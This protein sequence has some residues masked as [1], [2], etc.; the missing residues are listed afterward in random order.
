MVIGAIY[1]VLGVSV[2]AWRRW[3]IAELRDAKRTIPP[4]RRRYIEALSSQ[5][6]PK[7]VLAAVWVCGIAVMVVGVALLLDI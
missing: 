5:P 1:I 7:R 6:G 4:E 3:L 2:L